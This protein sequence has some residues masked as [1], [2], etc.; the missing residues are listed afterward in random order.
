MNKLIDM[1]GK[2]FGKLTVL[3]RAENNKQGRACWVCLCDCGNRTITTGVYLRRGETTS[4]GCGK[5]NKRYKGANTYACFGRL[6]A[7]Y[8][9]GAKKRNLAFELS[10]KELRAL[11]SQ[12]CHY[13]GIQPSQ[14]YRHPNSTNYVY[15]GIDR[16]DNSKG[17]V[18]GNMVP[19]CVVCNLAKGTAEAGEF[20]SWVSRVYQHSL[21]E[22]E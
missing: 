14:I 1:V 4:C 8:K 13:C 7:S 10:K 6:Y 18:Q 16:L 9:A 22:T 21:Q 12:N 5:G 15:N 11:T 3:A 17:Y 20:F 19:C 2:R